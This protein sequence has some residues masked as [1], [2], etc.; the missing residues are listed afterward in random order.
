M[1][2]NVT[3]YTTE[4][5][6]DTSS[7]I[8]E[9]KKL[10]KELRSIPLDTE[11]FKVAQARINDIEDSLKGARTG[12]DSF[13]EVLGQLPGPI[14]NIG[15][16]VAGTVLSLKT[17][18]SL[19]FGDLRNSFGELSKDVI[20][21]GKGIGRLTGLTKLYEFTNQAL[22]KSFVALGVSEGV[23][24]TGAK[25][26]SAALISTGI[27]ALVVAI[28]YAVS[29]LIEFA[30]STKESDAAA[31]AFNATIEEQERLL[32]NDAE[33]L[34]TAAKAAVTRAKIAGKSEAEIAQIQ[35]NFN[36]EKLENLRAY[37]EQLFQ[38]S[39]ELNK[40]DKL[41]AE[42]RAKLS[43]DLNKKI[44]KSGQDITKQILSNSQFELDTQ[45]S[46]KEKAD[47]KGKAL[48]EKNNSNLKQLIDQR[49]KDIAAAQK[50]SVESY[51]QTLADRDK[52]VYKR[53][54]EL[55]EDLVL[56]ENGRDAQ[57]AEARRKGIKD[58]KAIEEAYQSNVKMAK[59]SYRV[60]VQKI[61]QK[62]DKEDLDKLAE[63]EKK[64][65]D[66]DSK[67][68]E[69]RISAIKDE[70]VRSKAERQKKYDDELAEIE[71]ELETLK[72]AAVERARIAGAS[73]EEIANIIKNSDEQK[74]EIRK[75]LR[76]ALE[77]DLTKIDDDAK[78]KKSEKDVKELDDELRLLEL[79]SAGM[80]AGTKAYFEARAAILDAE[81]A[82]E[83]AKVDI[84]EAE[85]TAI[86]DK[87]T[88]LRAQLDEDEIASTG[89]VISATLDALG[90]LT[91]AI[92]SGYDEE[93]KTSKEAFEKRK[94]LQK[95]TALLSAA[96]GIVQIL[97]QP[98]T[99]PSPFDWIVKGINA[100]AL[101]V[102]TAV[103]I[104]NIDKTQFDGGGSSTSSGAPSAA[105]SVP[106]PTVPTLA[107]APVPQ[108]SGTTGGNNPS[109]QIAQ[110]IGAASGKPVKAYVVSGDVTS[111]QA[112]DR[113]TTR[114][115]TFSG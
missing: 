95:A 38:Q 109:S 34:D 41:S 31:A 97:T 93:A 32:Q 53:G 74:N 110:T 76:I 58:T 16:S 26:L 43:D 72:Q 108:I 7:S 103:Q 5:D 27:G 15:S 11:E 56:L 18:T 48:T 46:A 83:L 66:F 63:Q 78:L 55:T 107:S 104:K 22:S 59:E 33:A 96:S 51:I 35:K 60:D 113:R 17:F 1:A 94:K 61:E 4:I 82:K 3:K 28:G 57:L 86:K 91:S 30:G 88:K 111:Q 98:S 65:T 90:S 44:L 79:R 12:A 52:D 87:Y 75:N 37:D 49:N 67:V 2:D 80:I 112:L 100:V 23:A 102:T 77:N 85:K 89:K 105:A 84:T 6:I 40:N 13:V 115:A 99:L 24:A 101:G 106:K 70:V 19:K 9:L 62:Y 42:E 20:D 39:R 21:I 29:K 8:A 68:A 54:Q 36:K 64:V 10:K 45:L 73:E 69:I 50:V 92:A 71:K 47:A 25:A 114:A 81:E 14:G